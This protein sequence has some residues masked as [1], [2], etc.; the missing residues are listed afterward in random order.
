MS[1]TAGLEHRLG[2]L[3]AREQIE[4]VMAEYLYLVDRELDG[5]RIAGLFTEDAIWEPRGNLA[6][7][8]APTRGRQDI[9]KLFTTLPATMSFGAH[10]ITNAV[11]E[12][13]ADLQTAKG[14]WHAF[15]LLTKED[16]TVQVVQLAWYDND[17][18][19]QDDKWLIDHIRFEDSLSFPYGDGWADTRFVSLVTGESFPYPGPAGGGR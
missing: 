8:M 16:P 12:V 14:R 11:V 15:E 19:R 7:D 17:F 13:A 2:R 9:R 6:V 5:E 1:N 3:E 4:A 18:V 10:F